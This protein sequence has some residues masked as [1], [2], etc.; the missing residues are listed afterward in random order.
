[1]PSLAEY[2]SAVADDGKGIRWFLAENEADAALTVSA[3]IAKLEQ[4]GAA[5]RRR[6]LKASYM[7]NGVEVPQTFAYSMRAPFGGAGAPIDVGVYEEPYFNI[8]AQGV[9]VLGNRIGKNRPWPIFLPNGGDYR[10][11]TRCR[12]LTKYMDALFSEMGVY[13]ELP[14]CFK[15]AMTYGI[16]F[17]K[18]YERPGKEIGIARRLCDEIFIDANEVRGARQPKNLYERVWV[19]IE[20]A[21]ALFP[22]KDDKAAIERA[23]RATSGVLYSSNQSEHVALCE[24]YHLPSTAEAWMVAVRSPA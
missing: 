21:F 24:A 20:D 12:K 6:W 5:R 14:M 22:D 9:D 1:M 17:L 19:H 16:S 15:D 18:V 13:R 4:Q 23:P 10:T 11:R 7:I 2:Q 8:P 3:I